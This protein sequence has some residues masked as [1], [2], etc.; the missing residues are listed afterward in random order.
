MTEQERHGAGCANGS[1]NKLVWL[2]ESHSVGL[3][4]TVLLNALL[5]DQLLDFKENLMNLFSS[6]C[7]RLY[8]RTKYNS[9]SKRFWI[10]CR[11]GVSRGAKTYLKPIA[12][13]GRVGW[14]THS[15]CVASWHL[16]GA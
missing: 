10:Y 7:V 15:L 2:C 16:R 12:L 13:V 14:L 11:K 6:K 8:F 1:F 4:Q 9:V 5:P 3:E